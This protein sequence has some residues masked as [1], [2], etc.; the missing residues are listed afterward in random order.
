MGICSVSKQS[1][2]NILKGGPGQ[3]I[4]IVVGGAAES[5][6]AHPG[7]ADLTLRKRCAAGSR[8]HGV[9]HTDLSQA[10]I[11]QG[12]HSTWVSSML[13]YKVS[14][15][16]RSP[17]VGPTLS[18]SSPLARMT[19]VWHHLSWRGDLS[20]T[21]SRL[22][23]IQPDAEREGDDALLAA[24]EVPKRVRLHAAALP[25]ARTVELCVPCSPKT[26]TRAY[27]QFQITWA[28]CH[29]VDE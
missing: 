21:A 29:T 9:R 27:T 13:P 2:S 26:F 17:G 16:A 4:T 25:W 10:G 8:S 15:N 12:C 23:D 22:V 24:E 19:Y 14:M 28:C 3:A 20:L 5:L 1:C 6:S 7:T 18:L 11:Y